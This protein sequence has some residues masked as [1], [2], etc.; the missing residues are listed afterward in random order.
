MHGFGPSGGGA[1]TRYW[2]D[3]RYFTV[4][5]HTLG[6]K[7]T[8]KLASLAWHGLSTIPLTVIDSSTYSLMA[9][10]GSAAPSGGAQ[11]TMFFR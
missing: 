10:K 9:E 8:G 4:F 3:T 1:F 6:H 11:R 5:T 7:H 2:A